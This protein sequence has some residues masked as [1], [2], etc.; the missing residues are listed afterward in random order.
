MSLTI[1][2]GVDAEGSVLVK[3][4]PTLADPSAPTLAEV[5]AV[6]AIDLSCYL[7]QDG[8][9]PGADTATGTD[10]RL[11]TKQ[12]FE[13]KGATTW[14]I[15]NLIY[16]WDPQNASSDG[17]KAYAAM[18]EDTKGFLV[19]RWGMDVED[20][21]ALVATNV[22][23]IFTVTMGPQVPQPPEANSKLKVQQKPFVDGPT[24]RDVVLPAA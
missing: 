17:N 12:V 21:P 6:G 15:D 13:T 1:P 23:D 2:A 20:N 19:V 5:N 7:T 14:S 3:F 9:K 18:P 16:I 24:Y 10:P 4:V 11:C 22:I 8:F